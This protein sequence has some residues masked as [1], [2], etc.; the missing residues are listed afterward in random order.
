MRVGL[1]AKLDTTRETMRPVAFLTLAVSS[2]AINL[3]PDNWEDESFGKSVFIKF[4]AP[5]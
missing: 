5:W 3:T 2:S 1:P 4:Q